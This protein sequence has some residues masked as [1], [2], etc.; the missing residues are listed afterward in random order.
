MKP[1]PAAVTSDIDTLA[2]IYKGHG[3]RRPGGYTY[4]ELQMGLEN[5]FRF[6]EPYGIK[7]TLFMVGTD[8]LNDNS[9]HMIRSIPAIGHEIA[10]HTLSHIQGFRFLSPREKE[11]EIASMEE[12]CVRVTGLRPVGFRAPGWNISDDALPILQS[13]GYLYDSSIFSTFLMPAMKLMYWLVTY[14]RSAG[15][16][17]TMGSLKHMM[18][19]SIPYR[20]GKTSFSKKGKAGL[21]EFPIT[22]TPFLRLPFFAT[23]LLGAGLNH[24]KRS[25]QSLRRK[26]RPIQLPLHLSD[27]VNYSHADLT[28][29]VP[30]NVSGA[31][32]PAS[33][34]MNLE[35][36]I[37]V[38]KQAVDI[39]AEHY[40]FETLA[41]WSRRIA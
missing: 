38:F 31:Y 18:A 6:L 36:K 11:K 10:N 32:V 41:N 35:K 4:A 21:V 19:P 33:L 2:S 12:L 16:R 15:D 3:C 9:R 20:T 13:R 28:D 39:V 29:Q 30:Q 24:F 34:Y 22:V 17:T 40:S 5:F 7:A 23:S 37:D 8:F 14:R 1:L 27:F 25:C 26:K